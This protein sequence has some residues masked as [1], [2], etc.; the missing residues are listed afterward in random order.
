MA[1]PRLATFG[2]VTAPSRVELA[3][4]IAAANALATETAAIAKAVDTAETA[5][6]AAQA[7]RSD[8]QAGVAAAKVAAARHLTDVAL[9]KAGVPPP[10]IRSARDAMSAAEDDIEVAQ[11]SLDALSQRLSDCEAR[12][13]FV[14]LKVTEA[15]LDV[16]RLSPETA[17][18][19]T[20]V[21][22]LQRELA[23]HGAALRHRELLVV[24]HE[25]A[26]LGR[27]HRRMKGIERTL[28]SLHELVDVGIP[29]QEVGAV[30]GASLIVDV[31]AALPIGARLIDLVALLVRALLVEVA[32]A[33]GA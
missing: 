23:T 19:L 28:E 24:D 33:L 25:R 22:R 6:A 29:R 32:H 3:A 10:G 5:L 1:F 8:A 7:A 17:K 21:E 11:T 4:A 31:R 15:I 2:T 26:E 18:L 12:K 9:G 20:D 16:V 27:A 13:P 14:N 30:A